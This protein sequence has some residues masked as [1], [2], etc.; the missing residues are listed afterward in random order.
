MPPHHSPSY[1]RLREYIAERMR[2][3]HIY[4]PLMLMEL[5]GRHSPAPAEDIARRI[6]GEDV[7][8]ME[9]YAER[10]KRM[11]GRMLTDNGITR[12]GDGLYSLIGTEVLSD[13][14]RDA[15]LQLCRQ[16]LDGFREQ[17]G[18]E[19]FAHRSRHRSPVSG[20]KAEWNLSESAE[21]NGESCSLDLGPRTKGN[22]EQPRGGAPGKT[23]NQDKLR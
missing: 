5:L 6:L 11:V 8:Q 2:M 21:Q 3:S 9:Y 13:S 19:V 4:Q 16:R 23:P 12:Y 14:E 17:R 15:L 1:E 7:T 22:C 18:E 10:V 20:W